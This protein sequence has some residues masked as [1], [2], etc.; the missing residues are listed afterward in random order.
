MSSTK[1]V[2]VAAE[3]DR[4]LREVIALQKD[5]VEKVCSACET[6]CCRR[7]DR[8]FDEKDLVFAR[9]LGLN[10]VPS[11]R[12]TGKKGCSHLSPAGCLLEPRTRP[13]TCH[14]Y[15]CPE[16]KEDIARKDDALVS[17]LESKFRMLE[18]LRGQLLG[19]FI[20]IHEKGAFL[21]VRRR[22]RETN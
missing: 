2:T 10:G 8:L 15:L 21:D 11:R 9:V 13:F 5:H 7:V 17:M 12:R 20:L 19:E 4:L 16:L 6:P 3:I 1:P 18:E 14:R 22:R